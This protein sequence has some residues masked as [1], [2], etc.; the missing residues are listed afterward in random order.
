MLQAQS[1]PDTGWP[2]YCLPQ[3]PPLP[4]KSSPISSA[5]TP[6]PPRRSSSLSYLRELGGDQ[7]FVGRYV[8]LQA[9]SLWRLRPLQ[10]LLCTNG[11]MDG[12][13]LVVVVVGWG[14][15]VGAGF[16]V[17]RQTI[18]SDAGWSFSGR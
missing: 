14:G 9:A 11:W 2:T 13:V 16:H 4:I 18:E 8:L 1:L 17:V 10:H 7:S 3:T 6:E 5:Q 12:L 15:W